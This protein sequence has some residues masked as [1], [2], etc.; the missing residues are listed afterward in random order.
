L[1]EASPAVKNLLNWW[2][3]VGPLSGKTGVAVAVWL[4]VAE[5]VG[6]ELEG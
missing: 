6:F 3:P 2:N 4:V 1:A 5:L